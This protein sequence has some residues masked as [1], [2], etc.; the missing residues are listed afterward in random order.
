MSGNGRAQ[1]RSSVLIKF[2]QLQQAEAGIPVQKFA[3]RVAEKYRDLV[4]EGVRRHPL[5]V[6]PL[7]GGADDYYRVAGATLKAVQRYMDGTTPIPADVEEAWVEA[8]DVRYRDR[9]VFEL[10]A[11]YNVLPVL[12]DASA[13]IE[14][15]A[16]FMS[17]EAEAIRAMAP[18]FADGAIDRNDLPFIPVAREKIERAMADCASLLQRLDAVDGVHSAGL[19]M[20]GGGK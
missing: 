14:R 15:L 18:I 12:V 11:R 5:H 16:D 6:P 9:C 7:H 8:L 13:D 4:A 1:T 3:E 19:R 20:V 2:A 10:C 17:D